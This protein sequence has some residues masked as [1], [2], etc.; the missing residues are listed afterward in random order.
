MNRLRRNLYLLFYS[1]ADIILQQLRVSLRCDDNHDTSDRAKQVPIQ[2]SL[3]RLLNG[4]QAREVSCHDEGDPKKKS[5]SQTCVC[6]NDLE[7]KQNKRCIKVPLRTARLFVELS[8]SS[9]IRH[10]HLTFNLQQCE[11]L[12]SWDAYEYSHW[13]G[14][15]CQRGKVG[16]G[17]WDKA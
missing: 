16:M 13:Q 11:D 4:E 8:G 12:D 10:A 14:E 2:N 17:S 15:V 5:T 3:V 6:L 9:V 7:T 1:L